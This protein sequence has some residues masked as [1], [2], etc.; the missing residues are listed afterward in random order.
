MSNDQ[1]P[2]EG[3]DL[4]EVLQEETR[5]EP[6]PKYEVL[7][8]FSFGKQKVLPGDDLPDGISDKGMASLLRKGVLKTL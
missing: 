5:P 1:K 8:K 4:E 6:M 3:E 7:K 2:W